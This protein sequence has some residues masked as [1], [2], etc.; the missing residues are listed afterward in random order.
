MSEVINRLWSYPKSG[1]TWL[2]SSFGKLYAIQNNGSDN[3]V[4][5]FC[6]T[7]VKVNHNLWLVKPHYRNL[8]LVRDPKD[9]IV[10]LF[11]QKTLRTDNPKR[12]NH[13][14]L[15]SLSTFIEAG[16]WKSG[17]QICLI[18]GAFQTMV[19]YNKELEHTKLVKYESLVEDFRGNLSSIL[20]FYEWKHT[21]NE[22]DEVAEWCQFDNLQNLSSQSYFLAEEMNPLDV[23]NRNSYKFRR[24]K[25]GGYKDELSEEDLRIISKVYAMNDFDYNEIQET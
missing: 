14:T 21:S 8:F 23:E 5:E 10:S 4:M 18:L 7:V 22:L 2:R 13:Y 15:K 25:V 9:L 11:Y 12:Y 20:D 19:E 17:G 3:D 1:R 24:G 16:H 6:E